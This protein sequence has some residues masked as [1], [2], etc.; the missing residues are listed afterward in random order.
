MKNQLKAFLILCFSILLFPCII[1]SQNISL[2]FDQSIIRSYTPSEGLSIVFNVEEKRANCIQLFGSNP[3]SVSQVLDLGP[4]KMNPGEKAEVLCVASLESVRK[5]TDGR[6]FVFSRTCGEKFKANANVKIVY[7]AFMGDKDKLKSSDSRR[8]VLPVDTSSIFVV[9][10]NSSPAGTTSDKHYLFVEASKT[11]PAKI[12]INEDS[13]RGRCLV[14]LV[15]P[16][17]SG[18]TLAILDPKSKDKLSYFADQPVY[19]IPVIRP[20]AN[21]AG[22]ELVYD[23]GDPRRNGKIV[24]EEL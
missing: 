9:D 12:S 21:A 22:T 13:N 11:S 19:V 6:R 4:N 23:V 14:A 8:F 3:G 10:S 20:T 18:K 17:V 7:G 16:G 5:T 15:S 2:N 24:V 1:Y